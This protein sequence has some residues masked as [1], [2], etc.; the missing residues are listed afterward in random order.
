MELIEGNKLIAEFMGF[1]GGFFGKTYRLLLRDDKGKLITSKRPCDL[2]YHTS[3]D[4]LMPVVEKI[5][6]PEVK[7]NKVVRDVADFSIYYKNCKVVYVCDYGDFEYSLPD[8]AKSKIEAVWLCVVSFIQFYNKI[9]T[10]DKAR[11]NTE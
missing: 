3:W 4:W 6:E 11:T 5:S 7:G 2:K 10:N 1:N 8:G 9:K